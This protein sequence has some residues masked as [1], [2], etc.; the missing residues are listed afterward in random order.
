VALCLTI[1]GI[2]LALACFKLVPIS[3]WPLGVEIVSVE[4]ADAFGARRAW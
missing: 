1:I 4:E 3:F 2:P